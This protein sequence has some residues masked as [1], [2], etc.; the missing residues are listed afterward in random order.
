MGVCYFWQLHVPVP[1]P[2][3]RRMDRLSDET[4]Y[5]L[6]ILHEMRAEVVAH[7]QYFDPLALKHIDE[8]IALIQGR[9]DVNVA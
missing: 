5:V 6:I 8:A 3:V 1:Y 9:K 4:E 7:P 2:T